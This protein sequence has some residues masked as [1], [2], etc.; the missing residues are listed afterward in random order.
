MYDLNK[1]PKTR[2]AFVNDILSKM[3]LDQ[4]VGQC[5][6]IHWGGSMVTPYVME[7]VEKLHIGGIRVTPFGQNSR[8]GQ[9]YHQSLN[10]DYDY[11]EG[12]EDQA[13]PVHSWARGLRVA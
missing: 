2:D 11:P 10:Y 12:Q 13:E 3:T 4:K 9:H 6:T 1:D 8:R 7:A 5:F